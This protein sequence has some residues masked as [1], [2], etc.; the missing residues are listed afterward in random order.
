MT[1]EPGLLK[2]GQLLEQH[3]INIWPIPGYMVLFYLR[4][5]APLGLQFES[6]PEHLNR[7]ISRILRHMQVVTKRYL[8][9]D[10]N[11]WHCHVRRDVL[12]SFDV[13]RQGAQILEKQPTFIWMVVITAKF[14]Q[15]NS[16][17]TFSS[18]TLCIQIW[19][20]Q[21]A[22]FQHPMFARSHLAFKFCGC[23]PT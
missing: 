23:F 16:L 18:N 22:W 20:C 21:Q 15:H 4:V 13:R 5:R 10:I 8:D 1:L 12:R 3:A 6:L 2:T 11:L 17:S 9:F 14:F 7:L 19:K